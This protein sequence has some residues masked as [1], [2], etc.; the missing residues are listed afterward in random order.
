MPTASCV[1]SYLSKSRLSGVLWQAEALKVYAGEVLPSMVGRHYDGRSKAERAD[2]QDMVVTANST[3][4]PAIKKL[5]EKHV[6]AGGKLQK[7]D[8]K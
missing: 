1:L 3:A 4:A 5:L 2:N 7:T 8:A 6:G